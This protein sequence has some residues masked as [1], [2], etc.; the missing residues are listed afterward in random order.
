[1]EERHVDEAR[2]ALRSSAR[3]DEWNSLG[4]LRRR[5]DIIVRSNDGSTFVSE[6]TSWDLRSVSA[7]GTC[8]VYAGG[9][10]GIL[11]HLQ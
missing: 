4:S 5:H 3:R 9:V 7:A 2:A 10:G 1:V 6:N 11:V 8:D